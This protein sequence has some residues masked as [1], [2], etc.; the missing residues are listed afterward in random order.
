DAL[1]VEALLELGRHNI[2]HLPV[3]EHGR[4]RG[5][6]TATDLLRLQQASPVFLVGDIARASDVAA[7]AEMATRLR[8][9]VAGLVRQGTSAPDAGRVVTTVGDAIEQRLI[10]LAEAEIGPP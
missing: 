9:V 2:H 5:M 1:A 10:A 6:I 3:V 7:V 8:G 4:P